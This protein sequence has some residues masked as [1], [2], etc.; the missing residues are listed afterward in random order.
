MK[1]SRS[2]R[3][4]PRPRKKVTIT[5]D[6]NKRRGPTHGSGNWT[7]RNDDNRAMM[8]TPQSLIRG[9]SRPSNQDSNN[10]RQNRPFE[11]RLYANN[12]NSRYNDYRARSEYQSDQDQN[13]N[14][15]S[16]NNC[17]RS[18][19]TLR[20]DSSFTDFRSNPDKFQVTHQCFTGLEAETRATIYPTTRNSP[21]PTLVTS[22]T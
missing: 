8:S 6:Y 18:P 22:Q 2:C 11:R 19:S 9:N 20:Q 7:S 1:K 14:W 10:S 12:N 3:T 4:K 17:S 15:G 13:R 16:N 21:L 5:Q